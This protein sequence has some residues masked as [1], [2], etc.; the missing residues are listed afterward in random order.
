MSNALPLP[1]DRKAAP[2]TGHGAASLI[3]HLNKRFELEPADLD[4]GPGAHP[5]P[6]DQ[7]AADPHEAQ[8]AAGARS[9]RGRSSS[10]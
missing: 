8:R 7:P 1:D 2:R 5:Q 3:P 10:T 9:E 4:D 6:T